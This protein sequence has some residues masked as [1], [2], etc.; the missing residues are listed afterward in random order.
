MNAPLRG[1]VDLQVN[2][3]RG[4]DFS[5]PDLDEDSA[6]AALRGLVADGTAILLPT[7]ITS[8]E[9]VYARN[10]PL[11]ADLCRRR[12]FAPH[13]LGFHLEGPFLCPRDGVIGA[14]NPAWTR[15]GDLRLL[16]RLQDWAGGLVRLLT[17]AP[18]VPGAVALVT[19][20]RR[21]GMTVALGH[22]LGTADE[23]DAAVRAGATGLTH[24]GNGLPHRIDRHRNPLI[25][26]LADQRLAACVIGDGHHL[27][28]NLLSVILRAKGIER[29]ALVSDASSLAGMEPGT[30][31]CFGATACLT[32]EG[33]LYNPDTGYLMGSALT[34]RGVVNAT[35][36]AL[37]L[38][39]ADIHRL[40]VENPLRLIGCEGSVGSIDLPRA[41]GGDWE[42]LRA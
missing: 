29:C 6:A 14:H 1:F 23:I 38:T 33:R 26:G 21:L 22:H 34:I 16:E 25:D 7:L 3:F 10:L 37:S 20:A 8:P 27:P 40:A 15:P 24:L 36:R 12:E 28:W 9:E 2:G 18:E 5:A 13:V 30:Y 39:D 19:G 41:A 42:P 17:V 4:V 35:R 32:P 11:L 31:P